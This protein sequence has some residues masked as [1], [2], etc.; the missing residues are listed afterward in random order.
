MRTLST[1]SATVQGRD[2]AGWDAYLANAPL[3]LELP[4]DPSRPTE[5]V[6]REARCPVLLGVPVVQ[7]I[8][9]LAR[10]EETV[11]ALV[12]LAALQALLYRYTAETDVLVGSPVAAAAPATMLWRTS[13]DGD[14]GFRALVGRVQRTRLLLEP[15]APLATADCAALLHGGDGPRELP[16]FPVGFV[17]AGMEPPDAE[18]L[19]AWIAGTDLTLVVAGDGGAAAAEL[20]YNQERFEPATVERLA[21]HLQTLIASAVAE[22]GR[23]LSELP[24]LTDVERRQILVEWNATSADF[25]AD[26]FFHQLVEDQ[27]AAIPTAPAVV[28]R[29]ERLTFEQLNTRANQLAHHLRSL[30]AGEGGRVGLGLERSALGVVA[31]LGI[32]KTGASAVLLDPANPPS[33]LGF[34]LRDAEPLALVTRERLLPRFPGGERLATVCLDR[35]RD[36][37]ASQPPGT[38]PPAA[39]TPETVSHV[40]YTSG[41]TGE[42]KAVL[43]R[44]GSVANLVHWTRRAF[45]VAPGD[46][47]TWLSAPGFA[48]SLMEWLPHLASGA[49]IYVAD[50]DVATSPERI[51]DW[52]V[53]NR[54]NHTLL[55]TALAARVWALE[56]PATAALRFMLTAGELL[57]E[58]PPDDVPFEAVLSYGST[59]TTNVTTCYDA[60]AGI[61]AT[62]RFVP[63]A[64]RAGRVPPVGHPIANVRV[65]VLDRHG[66]P[67]PAGVPGELHVAGVGLSQGYLKQAELTAEKFLAN[68]LPEERSGTLFRTGDLARF[69]LD[70]AIE[71]LGRIDSQVKIRGFRVELGEIETTLAEQPAVDEVAVVAREDVPGDRRLVAYVAP[72]EGVGLSVRRLRQAVQA[73]LPH[74]MVPA[75]FVVLDALPRLPNG[76]LDRRALP[77]PPAGRQGL[78][79]E[80]VAPADELEERLAAIWSELLRAEQVGVHDSFFELGGHSL[81]AVQLLA[82]VEAELGVE[83]ALTDFGEGPTV[84]RVADRVRTARRHPAGA[85]PLPPRLV[86]SPEQRHEPFPLTDSQQAYW[87][88]RG[89]SVE[90][91]DV[92]CHGYFEWEGVGVDLERLRQAWQRLIERH[93]VLRLTILAS[94]MQQVLARVPAYEIEVLDL[95]GSAAPDAE[96]REL[97]ERLAHRTLPADRWPLFDL[98]ATLLDGDRTRVHLRLDLLIADAWSCFQVL[99]PELDR[100]YREPGAELPSLAVTFRD[101]VLATEVAMEGSE[102]FRRSREHWLERLPS[103]PAAPDLPRRHANPAEPVRVRRR[104]YRLEPD[105]W[106]RLQERANQIDV[107]ST[108]LL[109]AAFAEV[110]RTWSAGQRFTI[111][112]PLFNRAPLHEQVNQL[113]GDFTTT[114]LLAIEKADGTFEERAQSIQQRL[115]QDLEHRHFSGIRVLRELARLEDGGVGATMPVVVTSLLGQPTR[116]VRTAFGDAIHA[117]SHTPQVL[118]DHQ[119]YE[120]DGALQLHWDSA[121]ALFP[122]GVL[123]DMFAAYRRLLDRLVEDEASW[124][125]QAFQL[126]P[127][128]QLAQRAAVNAT[129][130]PV[131]EVLLHSLLAERAA[132]QPDAPAVITR[133]RRL[134]YGDLWRR[135]NQVGRSLRD[136]GVRPGELVAIVME[137]GWEQIVA[138]YGVLASGAAYLPIDPAVPPGRLRYLLDHGEARI[139][140]TQP[141]LGGSLEW[142]A[143]VRRLC[144]DDDVGTLDDSPLEPVQSPGDLAYV[145]Y[146]SGSTGRPK[147]VMV[148]HRGVLNTIVD[149]NRRFGMGAGD[150][151][152]AISPL[153]FDLSVA[154]VFGVLASGGAIVMP[155]PTVEPDPAGWAELIARERVTFWNSV[156]TL[157]EILVGHVE[158][159]DDHPL[160]SLRLAILAG[161]WIPLSL[162]DRLRALSRGCQVVGSGGPTETCVW[163][164]VYPIDQV[165]P[166]WTSIPYGRPMTNQ[167][168]HVL[169][170]RLLPRPV[171]VPGEI[172]V[173]SSVGLARGY[174]R[175]E[176]RTRERFLV[177][178]DTGER[179]YA[180]GDLG[181]YLPD[182]NIEIL[183]RDDFQVKIQG[184]RIELGEIEAMLQEHPAVRTAVVVAAGEPR[185]H[186]RLVAYAVPDPDGPSPTEDELHQLLRDKL[187]GYMV[188]SS[189]VALDALPLTPN[190]KID[191][192]ALARMA[193]EEP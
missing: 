52:L 119:F 4:Q 80:F 104:A 40:I 46:R 185:G 55:V 150:R 191:R 154:D 3:A 78:E 132:E 83:L 18:V 48:I 74:Y 129:D 30:G 9:S 50:A 175:D 95:R 122:A 128:S 8:A 89:A 103:F 33:R 159:R 47:A 22:P 92:G 144:V 77:E 127:E 21:R 112:F 72:P 67:V 7:G 136:L 44:H 71:I 27:A 14:P 158:G 179:V 123:D 164:V 115:W 116:Q 170:A 109:V 63:A 60:G 141:R 59:E 96:L 149:V 174:W 169:D 114:C 151:A 91:G 86:P 166:A 147:G 192:L 160:E 79:T 182:G 10:A 167:R 76:K 19:A 53:A 172:H 138:V 143:E 57:R 176:A 94:G 135:A 75:V 13:L 173:S 87:I 188:P 125:Q 97:R 187:P 26:R 162:P 145:I 25:P 98:R 153:H 152:F 133:D 35:D 51:R 100:L 177:L 142:P 120:L 117:A 102:A 38:P 105:A 101:C 61:R 189:I 81:L 157:L 99:V 168:Y 121:D 31:L 126:V 134:G 24:L 113:V 186:R 137:K 90:L 45:E 64:E 12:W 6:H 183:G 34:M 41:S 131:P 23:R 148:D 156:P 28:Y 68:W 146:T 2:R 54:I 165:D 66:N 42:P 184:Q 37:I 29:A 155:D 43:E 106:Q 111:N 180:S 5:R 1:G 130:A 16:L 108:G 36:L 181:R 107:T 62:P 58:W 70:G 39:I 139:A 84:A 193:V 93:D 85:A 17:H 65:Y 82:R 140:L 15:L 11:P 88:G 69:R 161:D 118:L 171:W 73:R 163:S 49:T 124:R 32:L 178:P 56:W 190:C 20:A 110:L